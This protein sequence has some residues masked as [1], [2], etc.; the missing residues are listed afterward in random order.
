MHVPKLIRSLL[1]S[2]NGSA[3]CAVGIPL[4][5]TSLM[6]TALQDGSFTLF[7]ECNDCQVQFRL[8]VALWTI[9]C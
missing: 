1:K 9:G 5:L 6:G 3:K 8:A 2:N 4:Q 7:Q